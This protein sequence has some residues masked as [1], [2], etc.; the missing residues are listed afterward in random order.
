[1]SK[2]PGDIKAIQLRAVRMMIRLVSMQ[3]RGAVRDDEWS[4]FTSLQTLS[5]IPKT[6]QAYHQEIAQSA[7]YIARTVK[8]TKLSENEILQLAESVSFD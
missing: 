8:K 3:A 2:S 1:M 4:E 7:G 5:A 6:P